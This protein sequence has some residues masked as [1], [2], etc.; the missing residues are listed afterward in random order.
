MKQSVNVGLIGFGIV[1]SGA[2]SILTDRADSIARKVGVPVKV[3]R[4]ADLDITTDRGVAV[5]KSVL[6]TDANEV[7]TDPD[8][9][10]VIETIGGVKP[11]GDFIRKALENGKN[12]VT[13]NKELIAKHG[14]EL[15]PLAEKNGVD[16]MFEAA[17]GGGIPVIRPMK[18]CLSGDKIVDIA[19]IVNG[20]TNYIL[21]RMAGE[22]L[23]YA[24][25]LPDAQA[26]GYAEANPTADVEGFDSA[27]KIS[28]LGSLAFNSTVDVTK[29]IREGI[30]DITSEDI[31]YAKK[32]GYVV[33]LVAM[34]T[35]KGEDMLLRVHP[36]FLPAKHPLAS[37]DDVF[38]AI[39]VKALGVGEVMFY[40]PGA[41][42]LAAGAAVVG[43][44]MDIAHNI[45]NDCNTRVPYTCADSRKM[46][47]A[48]A[49]VCKNYIR[50]IAEDN[51]GVLSSITG[52]TAANNI[53]IEA[54]TQ[55][56]LD[57]GKAEIVL[58]THEAK[59]NDV[60]KALAEIGAQSFDSKVASRIRVAE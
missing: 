50:I 21:T 17:V 47:G 39:Y 7:L 41:G 36:A 27:Y 58:L 60:I 57:G 42:S 8:I 14:A 54:V 32:L 34:A 30:T 37:V 52:I 15:L 53:S 2:I 49:I 35:L 1:G 44:V 28:I 9:D 25:V 22:G 33:K 6:T 48:D 13:A 5:D 10:I 56:P 23:G 29:V 18:V 20:T 19:G 43:D 26:K 24:E 11:A 46:L 51:P 31:S 3:K 45:M 59:E 55:C 16:L 12:V 4:I 40:G 38:N